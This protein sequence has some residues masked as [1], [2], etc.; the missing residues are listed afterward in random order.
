MCRKEVS[1]NF[2][3]EWL[4]YILLNKWSKNNAINVNILANRSQTTVSAS[5]IEKANLKAPLLQ[6][7]FP[8]ATYSLASLI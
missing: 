1:I 8:S 6:N 3:A 7:V 2:K 4:G 5:G